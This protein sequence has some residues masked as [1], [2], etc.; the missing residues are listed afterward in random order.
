[1]H[2]ELSKYQRVFYAEIERFRARQ[3]GDQRPN[4]VLLEWLAEFLVKRG[5]AVKAGHRYLFPIIDEAELTMILWGA[6]DL[7]DQ[8]L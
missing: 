6:L 1:M 5:A 7:E 2:S 4:V 3:I 8:G